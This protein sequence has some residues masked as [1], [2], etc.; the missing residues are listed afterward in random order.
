MRKA[1]GCMPEMPEMKT[2]KVYLSE[3]THSKLIDFLESVPDSV[4][5]TIRSALYFYQQAIERQSESLE[6]KPVVSR[7]NNKKQ[8]YSTLLG[9]H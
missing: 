4:S 3:T 8:K 7:N 5:N 2:Y 1:T 6:I 9:I